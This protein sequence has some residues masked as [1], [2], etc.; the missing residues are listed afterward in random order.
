MEDWSKYNLKFRYMMLSRLVM[1][2]NYHLGNGGRSTNGLWAANETSQIANMRALLD[3]FD[4]E[5]KPEWLTE[6][7]IDDY[8]RRMGVSNE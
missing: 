3:T 4:S 6:E 7:Q 5:D 1:D 8:A 2:C